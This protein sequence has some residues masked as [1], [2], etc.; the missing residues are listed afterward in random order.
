MNKSNKIQKRPKQK[1]SNELAAKFQFLAPVPTDEYKAFCK[2][3]CSIISVG[4]NVE[5]RIRSHC[6]S[7]KHQKHSKLQLYSSSGNESSDKS[8]D[9]SHDHKCVMNEN[10]ETDQGK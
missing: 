1:W 4:F 2:I 5:Q 8:T 9:K 6:S 7:K 3:C 10:K